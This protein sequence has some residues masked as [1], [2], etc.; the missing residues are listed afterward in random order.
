MVVSSILWLPSILHHVRLVV[1]ITVHTYYSTCKLRKHPDQDVQ[2][3]SCWLL[4][5]VADG[6]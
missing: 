6:P 4:V 1:I 2:G 3:F 5:L